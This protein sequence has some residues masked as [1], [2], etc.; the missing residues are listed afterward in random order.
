MREGVDFP[1][2]SV[3]CDGL[4]YWPS[5]G[6]QRIEAAE[7]AGFLE[8]RA[9]VRSG[10]KEDAQWDSYA[11][12]ATHGSRRTASETIR[13]IQLALRHPNAANMSTANLS[14]HLHIPESTVRYW[15]E[16]LSPQVAKMA[17][18]EVARG[19]VIYRLNV[20][21]IGK[22]RDRRAMTPRGLRRDLAIMKEKSEQGSKG[23]LA[24]VDKWIRG[25]LEA[26]KCIE[27]IETFLKTYRSRPVEP[28][29]NP[30]NDLTLD[31][32]AFES[33]EVSTGEF[34]GSHL[35]RRPKGEAK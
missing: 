13:V 29:T 28:P 21:N 5:D 10:T 2:I 6:F 11:A 8:I 9:E 20:R 15:R 35:S 31:L 7:V 34:A 23:L 16:R 27:L 30:V 19:G 12:N 26:A 3:C 1:P 24:I 18:R 14:K 22:N 4:D 17:F 25:Q 32:S 33:L